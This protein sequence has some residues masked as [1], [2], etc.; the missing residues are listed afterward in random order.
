MQHYIVRS[1]HQLD[2]CMGINCWIDVRL[3]GLL[4]MD[5][6]IGVTDGGSKGSTRRVGSVRRHAGSEL[7]D[8]SFFVCGARF[9]MNRLL[10]WL[11]RGFNF[12]LFLASV[13]SC[14][15]TAFTPNSSCFVWPDST[16][17]SRRPMIGQETNQTCMYGRLKII[18]NK[19]TKVAMERRESH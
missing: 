5:R 18:S 17:R 11:C 6:R 12:H 19:K 4:E 9:W 1:I 2:A 8:F 10:E 3:V 7:R 16:A 14:F 15:L 13:T